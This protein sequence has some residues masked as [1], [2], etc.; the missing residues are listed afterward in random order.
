MWL[1]IVRLRRPNPIQNPQERQRRHKNSEGRYSNRGEI[2][3]PKLFKLIL[4][5]QLQEESWD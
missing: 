5:R 1:A 3:K 2:T 4:Q